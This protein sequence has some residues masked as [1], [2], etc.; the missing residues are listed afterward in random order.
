MF[1]DVTS[2]MILIGVGYLLWK[3]DRP[4]IKREPVA[5]V[6]FTRYRHTGI[7]PMVWTR[8]NGAPAQDWTVPDVLQEL[9]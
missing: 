3:S 7:Q 2:A 8:G 9:S 4:I 5:D 6:D 1:D